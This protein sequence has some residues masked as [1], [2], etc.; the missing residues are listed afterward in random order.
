METFVKLPGVLRILGQGETKSSVL[1]NNGLQADLRVVTDA[2]FP[3]AQHYFTGSKEHNIVMRQRAQAR[4]YKLSE[5]GLFELP[6]SF[7]RK[8]E[9]SPM[10]WAP[11]SAGVT[12]I[13]CRDE[14][15]LFAALD[16]PYIPPELREDRGEFEAAEQKKLP[17]LVEAKDLKGVFHVHSTWSDGRAELEAMI[18]EAQAMGFDYVGISDHSQS[19]TYASGLTIERVKEQGRVIEAL[20]KK[21]KIHIFWGSEC[22]ILKTGA[23]DYPDEVLKNYDFVIASAHSFFKLPEKEMTDRMIRALKNKYV[24]HLGHIT[25]RLLLKREPYALNIEAVL[26]AAAQEGVAVEINALPDRLELDWRQIPRAK[27]LG[28]S[29][30]VNPDAHSIGDLHGFTPRH[31]HRAQRLAHQERCR[32]HAAFEQDENVLATPALLM[33]L[34]FVVAGLVFLAG[35]G[36]LEAQPMTEVPVADSAGEW[37]ISCATA[38]LP[39]MENQAFAD[40]ESLAYA[41]RWGA[42]SAGR[43]FIDVQGIQTV[44]E[45]PAY[46]LSMRLETTGVAKTLHDYSEKTETWLDRATL[47]TLRYKKQT[48]EGHYE[49]KEDVH[50]D[51]AC[52]RLDHLDRRLDKNSVE[53]K[54]I[55]LP[56]PTLDILGYIFYLR[57]LPLKV[58]D[59]YDLTLVSGDHLYPVTVTVKARLQISTTAGWFDCFYIEPSLRGGEKTEKLRDLQLWLTADAQKLPVRLRMGANFG[60]ITAELL[61]SPTTNP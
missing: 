34:R 20:R 40:H 23:M 37:K 61:Q 4:G 13:K 11:A 50:V 51:L 6:P 24:T 47:L 5:Y 12:S 53:R 19:A 15:E 43:G 45:R 46:Q 9:S 16:L 2:Q 21:F 41:V 38:S 30:S 32:Q 52:Q 18:A 39:A 55:R 26:K 31:R 3:F 25:G 36:S 59:H 8:P 14:V 54:Q 7:R 22:D 27:E 49:R 29:F 56:G 57:A 10:D 44:D 35:Y 17:A 58:G 33:R 42:I 48:H 28:C 60:H 1:F